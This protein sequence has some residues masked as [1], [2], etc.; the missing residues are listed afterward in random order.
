MWVSGVL[1]VSE[2]PKGVDVEVVL[3]GVGS[4]AGVCTEP[5]TK[6]VVG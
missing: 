1:V 6:P 2:F 4:V 5:K 3:D